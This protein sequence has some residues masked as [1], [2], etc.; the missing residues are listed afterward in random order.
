L[1]VNRLKKNHLSVSQICDQGHNVVFSTKDCEIRNSSSGELVAKGVRTPN[2]I[3]IL[4]KI[5]EDKCYLS[6]IDESWMWHKRLGH[7]SFDKLI[8]IIKINA[9]RAIQKLFKPN[10][11][12]CGPFQHG[13]QTRTSHKTKEFS[14]SNPLEIIHVDLCGPTTALTLQGERY[15][16]LFVDDY[17]R[18]MWV[19][20]IKYKSEAFVC[21]KNLKA[22]VENEK[23]S[24]IKCLRTD[25]G[26]EFT[27]K[28]FYELCKV[29]GSERELSPA[30]TPKKNGVVERRN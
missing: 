23:D 22:L 17:T 8:N 28:E 27:S 12:V 13:N 6:Q 26:G 29:H 7:A 11:G 14:T 2:N 20:S 25:R 1:V 4:N 15:F 3:Y 16:A 18:M 19:Y 10:Q 5:Q 21:L 24:K 30:R 9:V